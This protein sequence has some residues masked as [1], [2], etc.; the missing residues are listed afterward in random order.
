MNKIAV[1]LLNVE[2]KKR[3][4]ITNELLSNGLDWVHYDIMDGVFVPNTAI[5]LEQ[6]KNNI[7]KSAKHFV[8]IH[9]M[10]ASPQNYIEQFKTLA[11]LCTFHYESDS[12]EEI[13]ET[14]D[15]YTNSGIKVGLAIN[16]KTNVEQIYGLLSKLDV[17]L[18]MSVQP[19]A[20]G[21]SF[22]DNSIDKIS[23]IR[24][25][26]GEHNIELLIEVD[27]GINNITGPK[28]FEA[29]ADVLVS[30]SFLCKEPTYKTLQ[31]IKKR[32]Q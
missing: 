27:G 32:T 13:E 16:P 10:V 1:S 21:Q 2:D 26:I 25:Y 14:I 5:T 19:G 28:C 29:G 7:S 15:R 18:I 12:Y 6:V 11:D 17:V 3:S 8:D 9:L 20:G 22:K 30:G 31:S 4:L 23:K 24:K